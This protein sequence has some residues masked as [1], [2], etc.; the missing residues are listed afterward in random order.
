MY[1]IL[2]FVVLIA[3]SFVAVATGL[4][5]DRIVSEDEK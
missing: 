5:I 1:Y 3:A 4:W 2:W